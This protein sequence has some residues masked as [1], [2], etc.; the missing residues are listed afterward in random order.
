MLSPKPLPGSEVARLPLAVDV[1]HRVRRLLRV[2]GR[3]VATRDGLAVVE[4]GRARA[5]ARQPPVGIDQDALKG[6][7]GTERVEHARKRRQTHAPQIELG[8][9]GARVERTVHV[10]HAAQVRHARDR[11]QGVA[12]VEPVVQVHV[13]DPRCVGG[14]GHALHALAERSPGRRLDR[15]VLGVGAKRVGGQHLATCRIG[16][17]EPDLELAVGEQ[18]GVEPGADFVLGVSQNAT[19]PQLEDGG[20]G[21]LERHEAVGAAH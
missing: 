17:G 11:G 7:A 9:R 4:R 21:G 5:P 19:R 16:L 1:A 6:G 8:E 12:T 3:A 15:G 2:V 10:G 18:R 13:G 20:A 14:D